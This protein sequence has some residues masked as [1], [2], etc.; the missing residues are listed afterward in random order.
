[1][2]WTTVFSGF[3]S[4]STAPCVCEKDGPSYKEIETSYQNEITTI[5]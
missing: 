4:Y 1:M 3:P 2:R 5:I